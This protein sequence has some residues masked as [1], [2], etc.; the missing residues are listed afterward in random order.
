MS[1]TG[2][3]GIGGGGLGGLLQQFQN[4]GLG[5]VAQ[6]WVGN[7]PNQAVTPDQ[8]QNVAKAGGRNQTRWT[9][10]TGRDLEKSLLCCA[11]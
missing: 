10:T 5:H 4:A 6:S 9:G 7:G 8:L 1:D 11:S 3:G 2:I